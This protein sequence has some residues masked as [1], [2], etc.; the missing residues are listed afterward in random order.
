MQTA[1]PN[2]MEDFITR[3]A[4][5]LAIQLPLILVYLGGAVLALV[6]RRHHPR[7]TLF[8]VL[9]IVVLLFEVFVITGFQVWLPYLLRQTSSP[10]EARTWLDVFAVVRNLVAATGVGL[11]LM[12]VF[13]G[14]STTQKPTG[15]QNPARPA[16][17][18]AT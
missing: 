7:A 12:A 4:V 5:A 11:L 1:T 16:D 3:Y 8:T 13:S 10:S 18:P 2:M 6:R 9:A 14:R 15:V 17:A